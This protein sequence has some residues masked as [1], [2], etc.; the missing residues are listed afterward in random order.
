MAGLEAGWGVDSVVDARGVAVKV[1]AVKVEVKVA[2]KVVEE[3]EVAAVRES[4]RK[5]Q[6][7]L[8]RQ[9]PSTRCHR[10]PSIISARGS[11]ALSLLWASNIHVEYRPSLP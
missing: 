8:P 11:T 5:Q 9:L 4:R 10:I 6:S 1:V 2:V 7:C 3:K